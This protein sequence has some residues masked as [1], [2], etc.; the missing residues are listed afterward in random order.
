MPD[1]RRTLAALQSLLADNTAGDI[2]AQDVRDFLVSVDA[3]NSVQTGALASIPAA[4]QRVGDLYVPNDGLSVYRWSG[5]AWVPWGPVFPFADPAL[6]TFSWV[7]QGAASVATAAGGVYLLAPAASGD[8]LRIRKKAAPATPYTITGCF[9]FR[10][11]AITAMVGLCFRQSSD[12]KLH[13][14]ECLQAANGTIESAKWGG[15]TSFSAVYVSQTGLA[16]AGLLWLRIADDGSS[17]I[18]STSPDG[19][20]WQALHTVGR[21]DYL[22]AD[23]V[24]F[25]ANSNSA[26]FDAATTLLSWKEG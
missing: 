24:G 23:E 4:D 17:R 20:N 22:T 9:L 21:T 19:Q 6:Q 11:Q 8:N 3:A 10:P 14:L 18:C 2:S 25:L 15:P 12:G 5:S 7:N 16:V 13:I 1:T 26:S